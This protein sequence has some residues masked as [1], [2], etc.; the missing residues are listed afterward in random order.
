MGKP[1]D[2][3]SSED[4]ASPSFAPAAAETPHILSPSLMIMGD[5]PQHL[6]TEEKNK[7]Q[8]ISSPF[9]KIVCSYLTFSHQVTPPLLSLK[10]TSLHLPHQRQYQDRPS[11]TEKMR[12]LQPSYQTCNPPAYLNPKLPQAPPSY[13]K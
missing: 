1:K 6:S 8:L 4:T 3:V 11:S 10:I 2:L 12:L 9:K 7:K 5:H 13:M